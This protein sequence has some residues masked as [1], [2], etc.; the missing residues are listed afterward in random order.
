[1]PIDCSELE[2]AIS[3]TICAT[4]SIELTISF[5]ELPRAID[6]IRRPRE[7]VPTIVPISD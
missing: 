5:S 1:M 7:P 3:A 6:E 2:L 4:F